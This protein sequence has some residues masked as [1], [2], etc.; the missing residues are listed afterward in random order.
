MRL[1]FFVAVAYSEDEMGPEFQSKLR[2]AARIVSSER[3]VTV[4]TVIVD[5]PPKKSASKE[6]DEELSELL[7]DSA[8]EVDESDEPDQSGESDDA[9]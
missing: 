9:Q 4:R 5:A 1:A 8:R 2:E 7:R 3:N 6:S